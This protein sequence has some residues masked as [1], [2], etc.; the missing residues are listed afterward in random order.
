MTAHLLLMPGFRCCFRGRNSR[1]RTPFLYFAD[2]RPGS[3]DAVRRGRREFLGQFPSMAAPEIGDRLAD[4]SD[5]GELP[6]IN[7]RSRRAANSRE[8]FGVASRSPD[9][10]PRRS[11][12]SDSTRGRLMAPCSARAPGCC[13]FS[14][15]RR[16]AS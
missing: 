7:P 1:P 11:R 2:H 13:A 14:A 6:A 15:M 8:Q 12:P 5:A 10:A 9:A 4:P 3:T 16:P